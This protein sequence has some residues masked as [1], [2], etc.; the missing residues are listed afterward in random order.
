MKIASLCVVSLFVRE[1]LKT[2]DSSS[3]DEKK[4]RK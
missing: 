2:G 1:T 3:G 4:K